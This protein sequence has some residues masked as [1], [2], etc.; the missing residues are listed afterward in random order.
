M[1]FSCGFAVYD[2]FLGLWPTVQSLRMHHSEHIAEILVVD[3]NPNGKEAQTLK[4]FCKSVPGVRYE[5]METPTGTAPPRNRVFELATSEHVI[6]MDPHVLLMPGSLN[7]LTDFYNHNRDCRDHLV[8]GPLVYDNL[9]QQST[10]FADEWRDQ[11]WGTWATDNRVSTDLWFPI[12]AQGLGLFACSKSGWLGFNDKFRGFGGEEW[13]IHEKYR[14]LGRQCWCVSG[15][16]WVHRFG[17]PAGVPYPLTRYQKLRN[18]LIGHLELGLSLSRV[19]EHFLDSGLVTIEDWEAALRGDELPPA[20]KKAS[21]CGSCGKGSSS[22]V[23]T[24]LED[25]Y[26]EAHSTSSDINEHVPTLREWAAKSETV[27]EFGARAASTVALV[28]GVKGKVTSYAPKQPREFGPLT[29][30]AKEKYEFRKGDSLT[31]EIEET[32]GLFIDTEHTADRFY[33]ELTQLAPKVKHWIAAHDTAVYGEKS[34]DGGPG[35][36]PALRRFLTENRE[37][38]VVRRD[39]NN[40]G[41]VILSRSDS[42]KQQPPGLMRKALNFSKALASHVANGQKLVSDEVWQKRMDQCMTCEKRNMDTCTSCG[43]PVS[44]KTSWA[45]SE[46]PDS[47][48]RWRAELPLAA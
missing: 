7:A 6:C 16:K 29:A 40:N 34:P 38:T 1:R 45:S 3:N 26:S 43:C 39:L 14:Q 4:Q 48:P 27:V 35:L 9:K 41:L 13:Y 23:Y 24:T 33:K 31:T 15:L 46:C 20:V 10:H 11:M 22:K 30:L 19:R 21:G 37:W 25:W 42:D 32:D 17:R 47:P 36:L 44:A 2:D 5:P 12:P 28:A 8:Q 18:Y